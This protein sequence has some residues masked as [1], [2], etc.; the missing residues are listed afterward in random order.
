MKI[1][2]KNIWYGAPVAIKKVELNNGTSLQ[3]QQQYTYANTA[4]K[5]IKEL[6]KAKKF[7][8]GVRAQTQK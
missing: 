7:G 5:L 2:M 1:Y 8:A 4:K 3:R 6:S